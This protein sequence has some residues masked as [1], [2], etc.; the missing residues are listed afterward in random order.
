MVLVHA[1]TFVPKQSSSMGYKSVHFP[2]SKQISLELTVCC[3]LLGVQFFVD[4]PQQSFIMR[5]SVGR[6]GRELQDVSKE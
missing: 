6:E 1:C 3:V 5:P 4:L 2:P